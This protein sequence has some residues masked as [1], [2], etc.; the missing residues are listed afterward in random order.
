MLDVRLLSEQRV[1]GGARVG[2]RSPSPRSIALLAYLVLHAEVSQNR[3]H[4]AGVFWPDSNEAQARTNLRRELHNLRLAIGESPSLVVEPTALTWRDTPTCRVDVRVFRTERLAA[5][6]ARSAGDHAG[7]LRHAAAAIAEYRGEL[8]PGMYDDWVLDQRELLCRECVE[9]CDEAVRGWRESGDRVRAIEVTRRRVELEPLDEVGYRVLMELQA[10]SGDRGAVM[11]TYHRCASVLEQELGVGPGPEITRVVERLFG[12]RGAPQPDRVPTDRV[13][14]DRVPT[15]RVP[16]DRRPR[17]S[18]AA[19][20]GF[21]GRDGEAALL[22]R[23]WRQAT[24]GRGG[25]VVVSGQAGVGKSRLVAELAAIARD[26]G[27]AVATT[28]CFGSAGRLA[29]APVAEWLR[30]GDLRSGVERLDPVWRIEVERLVPRASTNVAETGEV[31]PAPG[32]GRAPPAPSPPAPAGS[33]P[34]AD[35][36]QRHR[37]FEGLARAVLSTGRRTLLVLDDLQWCDQ[38]TVAWLTFLLRF[39]GHAPLLVAA[40]VRADELDHN[41]E[42]AAS[43]RAWRS[44]RLVT[45]LSLA[46]LDP[47]GTAALTASLL[48]RPVTAAEA[49]VLH[50]ATGGYPLFVVE[51]ARGSLAPG[52][53]VALP[54]LR[55]IL[56]RRLEQSSPSAREVAALAAALGRDFSLDL[57]C[58]ASDLDADAL[59]QAVDELWRRRIVTE[60]GGGHGGGQGGGYDFSHDLLR[61]AAY[62]LVSPPRRWLLH[63][64]LAQGLELLH[65]TDLDEAAAQLA[66]QYHRGGRPDRALHYFGRAAEASARVFANAEAIRHHARCLELIAQLPPG[67]DRDERELDVAQAMTGPLNAVHGYSSPEVQS[68]LERSVALAERLSRPHAL[69]TSLIGLFT[70]RFV[71]GH[72]AQAHELATRALAL[73]EADPDLAGQAHFAYAGSATSLGRHATAITHF[74]R[75]YN[76]VPDGVSLIVG[77]RTDVHAMAWAAHAHWLLGDDARALSRCDEAVERGRAADHP[78][79]LTVALA[80]AALTHQLRG[81]RASLATAAKELDELCR[82]YEFAYYREWAAI[83]TGWATGDERGIAAIQQAVSRLRTQGARTRMSYWLSLLAQVQIGCGHAE[84]ARGILDAARLAAQQHDDRWWL[85]EVLR[86]RASLEPDQTAVPMLRRAADLAAD[87]LSRTLQ[88]RCDADLAARGIRSPDSGVRAPG[89]RW[90]GRTLSE[91]PPV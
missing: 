82:R 44:A 36:W 88:A 25:L 53:P 26:S 29:L 2:G 16:T 55:A 91:R 9:L 22:V 67:L 35:A 40:T 14:T 61:D 47:T 27:A 19:G 12:R 43:L 24:A 30:A 69:L 59:V 33:H 56:H 68:T 20:V 48:G 89:G 31:T 87:Q 41:A 63:R 50:A 54:N 80:Y 57:L 7:F 83:L 6:A 46:P 65:A 28:R 45:D 13:P 32:A 49:G 64:R 86:M 73:A 66:E 39:A 62:G 34:M 1:A 78:Y 74:D 90:S 71:Q 5:A 3:Q 4:L 85:P 58:E 81:D 42:V 8:L 21:V 11:R 76:L 23:R 17:R 15:D 75:A 72:T 77:T 52:E 60:Q 70:V 51:A 84:A 10:E 37:F 79:S 18:G 38:E